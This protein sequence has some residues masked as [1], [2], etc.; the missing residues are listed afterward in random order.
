MDDMCHLLA[1]MKGIMTRARAGTKA[2]K[3]RF[4]YV[5]LACMVGG[6]VILLCG[7]SWHHDW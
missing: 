7:C 5:F 4:W 6:V 1:L 2:H 3:V